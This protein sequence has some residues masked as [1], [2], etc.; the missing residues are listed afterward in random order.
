MDSAEHGFMARRAT[1]KFD[2]VFE[3]DES[4]YIVANVPELPG[5]HTQAKTAAQAARMIKEAIGLY[6]EAASE[7]KKKTAAKQ[8]FLGIRRIA[9]PIPS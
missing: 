8:K 5:C 6:L 9:V 3:K 1:R 4:G 7:Q 2:V